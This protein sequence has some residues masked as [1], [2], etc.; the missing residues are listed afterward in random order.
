MKKR[1][2]Q[3]AASVAAIIFL[4]TL[5]CYTQAKENPLAALSKDD[6]KITVTELPVETYSEDLVFDNGSYS[7]FVSTYLDEED[8][9]LI[10]LV[11]M[12]EA[13]GECEYGKRLVIDTI[14]NRIDSEYF[15]DTI[16]EVIYQP[17]QFECIWNGRI[18]KCYVD[19]D[20]CKLALEECQNRTNR[21]CVFFCSN[22]F[23]EY[24]TPMFQV[25][26]HYFSKY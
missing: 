14:L 1:M 11:T 18:E 12:G 19:D 16:S 15:P 5:S 7:S 21:E 17:N 26:H 9:E 22:D 20:I 6:F 23:G 24:G 2:I 10:A 25:Q 3:I 13:E 4:L 8:I